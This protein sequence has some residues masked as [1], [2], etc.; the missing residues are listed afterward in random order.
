MTEQ[1]AQVGLTAKFKIK[2]GDVLPVLND[3]LQYS[4]GTFPNFTGASAHVNFVMRAL[5]ANDVTINATA[6]LGN[7]SAAAS[8]GGVSYTLTAA[9]T[10]TPGL[11]MAC[12]VDTLHGQQFP[13]DGYLA[14]E[15]EQNLTTAG[16][17]MLLSVSDA[18]DYLNIPEGLRTHDSKLA[19]FINGMTPVVEMLTG[20]ILQ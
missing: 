15:V 19:R 10:K 1:L 9:D 5:T 11:Y 4:D 3:Q 7:S 17:A 14:V 13:S 8:V 6:T 12:W 20:P 16:G 2:Q 18:K